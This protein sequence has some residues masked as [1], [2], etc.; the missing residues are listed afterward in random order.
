M[1]KTELIRVSTIP[2]RSTPKCFC[3]DG[4]DQQQIFQK[5]HYNI[6]KHK[7]LNQDPSVLNLKYSL[8]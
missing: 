8:T 1:L 3:L 4:N 2:R 5:P 6:A 7:I